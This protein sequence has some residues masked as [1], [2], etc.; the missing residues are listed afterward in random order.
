MIALCITRFVSYKNKAETNFLLKTGTRMA[1]ISGIFYPAGNKESPESTPRPIQVEADWEALRDL[2]GGNLIQEIRVGQGIVAICAEDAY[3]LRLPVNSHAS[4][5]V[6]MLTALS[7]PRYDA[8][9][10]NVV[11]IGIDEEGE[12]TDLPDDVYVFTGSYRRPLRP[13]ADMP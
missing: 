1:T 4:I 9:A 12:Y 8:L 11:L 2:T 5:A 13:D 7:G 10:G 6:N 3:A